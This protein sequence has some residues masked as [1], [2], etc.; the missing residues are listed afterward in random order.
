MDGAYS[1]NVIVE[2]VYSS[3]DNLGVLNTFHVMGNS[4]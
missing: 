1:S 4:V 2:A 3:S